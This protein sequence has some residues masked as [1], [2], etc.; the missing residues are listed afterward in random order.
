MLGKFVDRQIAD[1][2]SA[3]FPNERTQQWNLS[4]GR[5][6]LGVALDIAYVG[7]RA[8]NI[9]FSENLNLL[10]P[11]TT[12]FSIARRPYPR[13]NAALLVQT[14]GSSTYHGFTVQ[15]DRRMTR[16]L[17]F[18]ANYTLAKALTDVDMNNY[19]NFSE[20]NQYDRSLERADDRG[21]RRQQLRTSYVYDLPVRTKL[22]A[23]GLFV[24][25]WQL[26][27]ILTMQTGA[28]LSPGYS[29]ADPANVGTVS[30]RPDRIGTGTFSSGSTRD[31]IRNR[32]P[33]FDL[34]AFVLPATGRGFY[35]NS[36]RNILSAPGTANWN[37]GLHK[38][39]RIGEQG[40][41]IQFRWESFNVLNRS[42]FNTPNTN[43][44][45]GAFGLVTSA[46]S[47]RSMLFGLRVD[48]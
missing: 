13:Y 16:G 35:G 20:Q 12:P 9:P 32:Q 21:V 40:P 24:N 46:G 5:Q 48:Y 31:R 15:A 36:G 19:A 6:I 18:N 4:L 39:W 1:G 3:R 26:A 34:A 45:S 11:S 2:L 44:Q 42:N 25:G 23:L 7:T 28:R 27:G 8:A 37:L 33:V 29:N 38:N 41:S 47:G 22:S 30:G 17:W 14:G 43:I 10:R